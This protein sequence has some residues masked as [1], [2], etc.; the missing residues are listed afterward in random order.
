MRII[1]TLLYNEQMTSSLKQQVLT[2]LDSVIAQ[3]QRVSSSYHSVNTDKFRGVESALPVSEI[4]SAIT[5]GGAVIEAIAGRNTQFFRAYEQATAD[6]KIFKGPSMVEATLGALL[7]LKAA[8]EKDWLA[9]LESRLRANVHDDFLLQ[10]D[11]LL[12]ARFHVAGI[13]LIGGVLENHLRALCVARALSLQG[14]GNINKYNTALYNA[15][16]YPVHSMRRIQGVADLRNQAAHG[17]G[18]SVTAASVQHEREFVGRFLS[19][20]PA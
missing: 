7:A 11:H 14:D 13:V 4:S 15:G 16:L 19:E 10:A 18:A 6:A 9:S 20:Y 1:P 12:V 3:V 8:V 17:A 5:G 2:Q